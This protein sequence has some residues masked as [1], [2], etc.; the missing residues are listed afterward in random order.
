MAGSNTYKKWYEG[1]FVFPQT[2]VV[3]TDR[4]ITKQVVAIDVNQI[5]F[6]ELDKI[7]AVQ[8]DEGVHMRA[9]RLNLAK[10]SFLRRLRS[11]VSLKRI[12]DDALR[13]LEVILEGRVSKRTAH[14]FSKY[15]EYQLNQ[16]QLTGIAEFYSEAIAIGDDDNYDFIASPK[17]LDESNQYAPQGY[18]YLLYDLHTWLSEYSL[19]EIDRLEKF[20]QRKISKVAI[21]FANGSIEKWVKEEKMSSHDC[22]RKL[23]IPTMRPYISQTL[24]NSTESDKNIYNNLKLMSKT[25]KYCE[26]KGI[27]VVKLF[28]SHF[29]KLKS[30]SK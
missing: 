25:I 20:S 14:F 13:E 27:E 8:L 29:E 12:V 19:D 2:Y 9:S 26:L 18:A 4:P 10:K 30:L 28:I 21:H 16:Q 3:E 5:H 6:T 22:A 7:K 23:S 1:K 24:S 15:F 17:T 11:N